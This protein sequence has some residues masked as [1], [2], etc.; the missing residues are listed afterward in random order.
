MLPYDP[1]PG[2]PVYTPRAFFDT[3]HGR[4]EVR[5]NIVEAPLACDSFAML[6]RRGFY[7]GL[8]FHRVV[9]TFVVQGGC[10]RGDGNGGPGYV[11]RSEVGQR[12]FGRG[13]VGLAH[14]GRDTEGSQ[15]FITLSPQPHL[16]GNFT[17]LGWVASGMEVVEQIQ[18]GDVIERIEVWDGR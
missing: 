9:P 18:P 12:P 8:T 6:A 5:L 3:R 17:V 2:S 14:S 1:R 13:T 11:L 4:F 7:N 10:P 15:L 16:D